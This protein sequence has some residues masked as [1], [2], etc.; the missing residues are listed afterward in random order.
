M[1]L[2]RRLVVG[3]LVLATVALVGA[4]VATY[5]SLRSFLLS[6]TDSSLETDHRAVESVVQTGSSCEAIERS[7][8]G[9]FVQLR[10]PETGRVVC[11]TGVADISR[12]PGGNR[13]RPGPFPQRAPPKLPA[14]I[15]HLSTKGPEPT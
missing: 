4:D 8:P 5:A 3:V 2:R 11:S 12:P 6:R 10:T 7:V 1:S 15:T 9:L 13:P 14:Q